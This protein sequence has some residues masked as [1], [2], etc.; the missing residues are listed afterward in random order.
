MTYVVILISTVVFEDL[1]AR[2]PSREEAQ[3]LLQILNE[4]DAT[5]DLD[6]AIPNPADSGGLYV[7]I[8]TN[9]DPKALAQTLRD[10]PGVATAY[11]KP[12]E[13]MP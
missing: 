13:E 3:T 4:Q 7:T 6:N 12:A 5:A 9:S 2:D 11:L 8:S 1:G 10:L